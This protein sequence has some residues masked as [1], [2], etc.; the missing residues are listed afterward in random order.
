MDAFIGFEGFAEVQEERKEVKVVEVDPEDRDVPQGA[1]LALIES[2]LG[3]R[4][5]S[6]VSET[7]MV[8][9]YGFLVPSDCEFERLD[10]SIVN[11]HP[12]DRRIVFRDRDHV[13]FIDG[14]RGG[15][16]SVT[17]VIHAQFEAFDAHKVASAMVGKDAFKRGL[18]R[19]A[20]Y[21]ELRA[22][23]LPEEEL[24]ERIKASWE[25][26][27]EEQSML[28]TKLHRDAELFYNGINVEND[29]LEYSHFLKYAASVAEQ[30]FKM[31][32]TEITVF[33]EEEQV[34]GSVD[35]IFKDSQG[36][37]RLRDWKR[38]K[39]ISFFGF[40]KTGKGQLSHLADC[41]YSHY[42]LQLNL[43][44]FLL[45]KYYGVQIYDMGLVVFHPSNSSFKEF[46]VRKMD[47]EIQ[48][49]LQ[50]YKNKT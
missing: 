17:T 14:K 2:F 39:E 21:A 18:K 37:Y 12:R 38:S 36:R 8:E 15:F 7:K 44:R 30:G 16:T 50:Q 25:E 1:P 26:F 46:S 6:D 27:G 42:C 47:N 33:G 9:W 4:G 49:L 45:E 35:A 43:Y 11:Q 31:Y 22:L 40:G 29:S 32:R 34:C 3:F 5:F 24:I 48:V 20:K 13:Y 28:G 19:Y 41:N 10:L 23:H